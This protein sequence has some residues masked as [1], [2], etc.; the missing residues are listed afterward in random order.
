MRLARTRLRTGLRLVTT[1]GVGALVL[2]SCGTAKVVAPRL[3]GTPALSI[4]VPL[5][6]VGCTLNDVC[7][8]VGTSS[9]SLGPTSVGEFATPKGHW[10]NLTLPTTTSPLIT[11]IACSGTQCLLGGSQPGR[12]LLWHF[13][14][15]GDALSVATPPPG[16]VGID[17]LTCDGLNCAL[18]DTSALTD[19]PRFSFSADGGLTWSN[20]LD[21]TWATSDAITSFS[22]GAVF[23][24]VVGALSSNHQLSLYA[25]SDG[26]TTWSARV[27]PSSWTDLSSLSCAR[28]RC[29]ALA[30]TNGTSLLVRS[31]NLGDSWTSVSL[32]EQANAL[33]CTNVT[34]CVVVGQ[35]ADETPWLATVHKSATTTVALRYVPTP[36][37]NVA[38][39]SKVCA[40]IG[41]TTLLS[42]PSPL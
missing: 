21:M 13:D 16:G 33:A 28:D 34:S 27:T 39:G 25:T 7:V 1:L 17:A 23:N 30:S 19:T 29:V 9:E 10:A 6:N 32:A 11:S 2:A 38:C 42:V 41:V 3:S 20:P 18:V 22:C 40:A 26:G 36:L 12:D 15:S 37:L 5:S 8:A 4:S 31:R 24:C 14:A 35:H